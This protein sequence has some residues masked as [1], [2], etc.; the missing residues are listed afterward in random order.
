MTVK[1]NEI[2]LINFPLVQG[3]FLLA[4]HVAKLAIIFSQISHKT[5]S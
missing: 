4:P 3:L 2:P 1:I 5:E